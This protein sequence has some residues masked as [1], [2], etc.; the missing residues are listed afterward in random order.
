MGMC[1]VEIG[2]IEIIV[3]IEIKVN[4]KYVF[5]NNKYS[6]LQLNIRLGHLLIK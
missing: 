2:V 4:L 1:F 6:E 5:Y 3:K